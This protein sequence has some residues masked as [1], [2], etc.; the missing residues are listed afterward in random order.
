MI[1]IC[2]SDKKY[3]ERLFRALEFRGYKPVKK[4]SPEG[5]NPLLVDFQV[6][7]EMSKYSV[8]FSERKL[9]GQ[10]FKYQSIDNICRELDLFLK[11]IEDM[12]GPK[13]ILFSNLNELK[14]ENSQVRTL[15]QELGKYGKTLLLNL[16]NFMRPGINENLYRSLDDLFLLDDTENQ[17]IDFSG[18]ESSFGDFLYSS[19]YP[20]ELNLEN[21]YNLKNLKDNLERL[22]YKF[23]V[24]DYNFILSSN[25]M[26]IL[27]MAEFR[28]FIFNGGLDNV[29][30]ESI[31]AF[32]DRNKLM[33]SRT[34]VFAFNMDKKENMP[35][36]SINKANWKTYL[37]ENEIIRLN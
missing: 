21:L 23:I 25:S 3:E 36:E 1:N 37:E 9:S 12:E 26:K 17:K 34:K 28:I 10:I 7:N 30:V 6:E 20:L 32:L 16:N 22:K 2:M 29:Y 5:K 13:I 18:N 31:L 11:K 27:E 33:D 35:Y 19:Y 4:D 8:I 24:L 14:R 15:L